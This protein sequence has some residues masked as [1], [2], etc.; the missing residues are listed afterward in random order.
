MKRIP[1]EIYAPKFQEQV[2]R[3]HESEK[4]IVPE[5]DMPT[6]VLQG[7]LNYWIYQSRGGRLAKRIGNKA[8]RDT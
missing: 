7:K 2:L 3:L 1:R 6:S 4:L 5:M 8:A